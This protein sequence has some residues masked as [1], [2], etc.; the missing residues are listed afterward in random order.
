MKSRQWFLTRRHGWLADKSSSLNETLWFR[1]PKHSQLSLVQSLSHGQLF[2]IPWT[3]AHQASPSF[4]G[5]LSLLKFKSIELVRPSNDLILCHPLLLLPSVFPSIRIFSNEWAL[6]IMWESIGASALA[7]VLPMNIQGWFPLGLT[8]LI[9][10]QSKGLSRI[11]SNTTVQKHQ[12]F[13]AQ[14]SS[15]SNFLHSPTLVSIHDH[16]KNHGLD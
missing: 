2:A 14:L 9:S 5:S 7:S 16:W 15:Q 11:F 12:F 13:G 8:G 3:A 1:H 6:C 10:L 4:T